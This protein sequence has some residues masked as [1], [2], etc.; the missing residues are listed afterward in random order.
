MKYLLA[1]PGGLTITVIV[2]TLINYGSI[3]TVGL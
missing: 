1:L 3:L 2:M